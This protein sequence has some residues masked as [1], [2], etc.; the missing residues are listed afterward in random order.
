MEKS[1]KSALSLGS[2]SSSD[3]GLGG[4]EGLA[5]QDGE[6]GLQDEDIALAARVHHAGTRRELGCRFIVSARASTADSTAQ[7]EH[8][9]KVGAVLGELD[10]GSSRPRGRR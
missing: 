1:E 2:A 10:G 8:E 5:A 7:A 9:L 6:R 4:D 3:R